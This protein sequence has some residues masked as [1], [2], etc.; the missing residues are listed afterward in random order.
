[1]EDNIIILTTT[2]NVFDVHVLYQKSKSDRIKTYNKSISKWLK[3]NFK[4]IV[5]DNSGYNFPNFIENE[6]FI[7]LNYVY[8][9]LDIPSEYNFIRKSKN[10]GT[11]EMLSIIYAQQN[12][13]TCWKYKKIFKLTGRYFIPYF[14]DHI[15]NIDKKSKFY[16]QDNEDRCELFGCHKDYFNYLFI[17]PIESQDFIILENQ[18]KKIIKEL[19]KQFKVYNFPK[20]NVDKVLKGSSN[21]LISSL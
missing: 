13:P 6:R 5:V 21:R 8:E 16:I 2:V 11:H 17:L 1:M 20:I 19:R 4:I 7:K 18:K 14:Y 3:T 9:E 15:K 10:K 12:I